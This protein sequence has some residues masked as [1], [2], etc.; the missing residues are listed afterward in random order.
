M[1]RIFFWKRNNPRPVAQ[2]I[3]GNNLL[4]KDDIKDKLME[5]IE[6]DNDYATLNEL[7]RRYPCPEEPKK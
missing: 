1:K 5:P 4:S 6:I 3:H 7:I 2:L